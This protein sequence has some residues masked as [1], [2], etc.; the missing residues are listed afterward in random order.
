MSEGKNQEDAPP[1]SDRI[2]IHEQSHMVSWKRDK[3]ILSVL[4]VGTLL[5]FWLMARATE[6]VRGRIRDWRPPTS[7]YLFNVILAG[8]ILLAMT[9]VLRIGRFWHQLLAA[10]MC[11]FPAF[12]LYELSGWAYELLTR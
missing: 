6:I 12:Y 3:Y 5:E 11:M 10:V 7:W 9:R 8:V 1:D 4:V 2:K